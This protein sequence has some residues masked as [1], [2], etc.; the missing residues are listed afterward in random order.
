VRIWGITGSRDELIQ[1]PA[2]PGGPFG[3]EGRPW[4]AR[5]R[6]EPGLPRAYAVPVAIVSAPLSAW[7]ASGLH[8]VDSIIVVFLVFFVPSWAL[9]SW[10][11]QR[12]RNRD[13]RVLTG[14]ERSPK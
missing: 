13:D 10:W 3:E 2:A 11:K 7:A 4:Y 8:G 14:L 6:G 9:E 5:R 1:L 12:R